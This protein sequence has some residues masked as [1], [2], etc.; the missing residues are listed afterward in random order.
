MI[1]QRTYAIENYQIR[2]VKKN[3]I[4]SLYA[5]EL[6][7]VAS[8]STLEEAYKILEEQFQKMMDDYEM[9]EALDDL[10]KPTASRSSDTRQKITLTALKSIVVATVFFFTLISSIN[11]IEDKLGSIRVAEIMKFQ[12]KG[13]REAMAIWSNLSENKR[14]ALLDE[15][16]VHLNAIKPLSDRVSNVFAEE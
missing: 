9:A 1:S 8:S 11:F 5:P 4:Y 6:C 7:I 2:L 3:G 10:P 15:L 14:D 16:E 12:I 13:V